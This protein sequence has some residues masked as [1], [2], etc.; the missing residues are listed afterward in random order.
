MSK[1]ILVIGDYEAK[2]H[3]LTDVD[4]ELEGILSGYDV[5]CT[6]DYPDLD[7]HEL[8]KYDI[9]VCYLDAWG[10][11]ATQATAGAILS[12]VAGGGSLLS[13]HSGIIMHNTPEMEAMQGACFTGHPAA[14]DLTYIPT[15]TTHPIMNGIE[16]F[17]IFEE[18]YQFK[19]DGIVKPEMLLTFAYEDKSYEAAWT[20]PYGKG[21]V[22]YLSMGHSAKSF[23]SEMFGKM[24]KNSADWLTT[25]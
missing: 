14:C 1:K 19:M 12:Y 9:L 4:K 17:V 18:P 8:A 6:A 2:W 15:E 7:A 24:I 25:K 20:L 21:T 10:S 11:R 16:E 23:E 13:I 22:V 3:P 5:T